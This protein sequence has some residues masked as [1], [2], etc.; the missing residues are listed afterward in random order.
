[1]FILSDE[2]QKSVCQLIIYKISANIETLTGIILNVL[3]LGRINT[4]IA[5]SLHTKLYVYAFTF[6]FRSLSIKVINLAYF[7]STLL[8]IKGQLV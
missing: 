2:L 3:N 6:S 4:L 5:V 8:C 7:F 1:M